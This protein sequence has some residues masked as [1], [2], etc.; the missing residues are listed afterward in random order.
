VHILEKQHM[1]ISCKLWN[2]K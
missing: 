2:T 1:N